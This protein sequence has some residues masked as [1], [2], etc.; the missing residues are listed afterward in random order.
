MSQ[1]CS[2]DPVQGAD[3]VQRVATHVIC[4][5]D[6]LP[7]PAI[8]TTCMSYKQVKGKAKRGWSPKGDAW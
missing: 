2:L 6:D 3:A 1:Q 4:S 8:N 5:I 7:A